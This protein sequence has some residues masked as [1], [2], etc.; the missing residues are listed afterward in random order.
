MNEIDQI[1]ILVENFPN[2]C[3]K[4]IKN[5]SMLLTFVNK[6]SGKELKEKIYIVINGEVPHLCK[7]CNK[8]TPFIAMGKGYRLYCDAKCLSNFLKIDRERLA[9]EK[10]NSFGNIKY[11][12]GYEGSHS[13]VKVQ[14][15]SCGCIFD[16]TYNNIFTNENYCP[17]HGVQN[18]TIKLIKNN[19]F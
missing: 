6:F 8:P 14:N 7:S 10:V 3:S 5:N 1:K 13:K 16:V 4:M 19:K 15:L 11:I 2:H 17:T 18:R 12:S 9:I